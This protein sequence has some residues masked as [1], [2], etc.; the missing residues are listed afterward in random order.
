MKPSRLAS[1]DSGAAYT[2][3]EVT[4]VTA[5][6]LGLM[7]A[8]FG[9]MAA[10]KEGANRAVCIHRVANMQKAMR[11]YCH[12]REMEPGEKV[13]DLKDRLVGPEDFIP[14]LPECPSGGTYLFHEETVPQI[15]VLFMRCS[16]PGHEPRD[17]VG[18]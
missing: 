5:V 14:E 12:F 6:L 8:T 7:G 1:L 3:V 11:A 16:R 2:L 15:G 4:L 13:A 17:T 9:G 10:Y 18:W